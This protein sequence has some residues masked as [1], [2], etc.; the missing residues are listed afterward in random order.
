MGDNA[1]DG[2]AIIRRNWGYGGHDK[3]LG[4]TTEA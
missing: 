2:T 3:H 4:I 1:N